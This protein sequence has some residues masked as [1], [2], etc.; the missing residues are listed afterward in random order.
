M[1][2]EKTRNDA[3]NNTDNWLNIIGRKG[4]R[5]IPKIAPSPR[6]CGHELQ[7]RTSSLTTCLKLTCHLECTRTQKQSLPSPASPPFPPC[8]HP[9]LPPFTS[10][11]HTWRHLQLTFLF[12]FEFYSSL[13]TST[14]SYTQ[15]QT[16]E[17]SYAGTWA[18][19]VP[20]WLM[21]LASAS[22]LDVCLT[23]DKL[24]AN[25]YP[26]LCNGWMVSGGDLLARAPKRAA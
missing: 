5:G 24:Q 11:H 22:R 3:G 12:Y 17:I 16:L 9:S 1:Q 14:Q 15:T 20:Y 13:K 4:L 25:R 7:K 19:T 21:A 18:G 23:W 26:V 10:L 2:L 6:L 8:P